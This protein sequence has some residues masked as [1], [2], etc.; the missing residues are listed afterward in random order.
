MTRR[1]QKDWQIYSYSQCLL[2]NESVTLLGVLASK[3]PG[4]LAFPLWACESLRWHMGIFF[5]RGRP[6]KLGAV[7]SRKKGRERERMMLTVQQAMT[8]IST[9]TTGVWHAS[10]IVPIQLHESAKLPIGADQNSKVMRF[11]TKLR[12]QNNEVLLEWKLLGSISKMSSKSY[13]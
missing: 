8:V 9:H 4:S 6:F 11:V 5:F 10:P 3:L 13:I 2:F 12:T 1:R 7:E